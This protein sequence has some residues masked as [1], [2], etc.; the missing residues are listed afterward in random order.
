M[1]LKNDNFTKQVKKLQRSV[2][3]LYLDLQAIQDEHDKYILNTPK[4][5][6]VDWFQSLPIETLKESLD[7]DKNNPRT[8]YSLHDMKQKFGP[9]KISR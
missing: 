4:D 1:K 2:N 6:A 8:K 9:S 5:K 3:D 7:C